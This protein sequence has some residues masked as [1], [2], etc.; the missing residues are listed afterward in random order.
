LNGI[1]NTLNLNQSQII[2]CFTED[3]A[4]AYLELISTNYQTIFSD[5]VKSDKD[6]NIDYLLSAE[7]SLLVKNATNCSIFTQD[8]KAL[9]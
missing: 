3:E 2:D 1:F 6:I 5:I 9:V 7:N 8:Y 4:T